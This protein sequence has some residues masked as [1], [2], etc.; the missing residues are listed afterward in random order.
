[1][2]AA[3][4]LF[5][6]HTPNNG[7][8]WQA[9]FA[10]E[11]PDFEVVAVP[12]EVDPARV[13]YLATWRPPEGLF[14]RF[15]NLRASLPMNLKAHHPGYKIWAGAQPDIDRV[16]EIW[17]ECLATYGGPFLF[18]KKRCMADAMFAPVV[19]RF[20]SYAVPMDA[21]CAAY[22]KT[23]A[24]MPEMKEWTAAAVKEAEEIEELD[25]EF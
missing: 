11:L 19:T 21:A 9:L 25:M 12:A 15:A 6:L 18:G 16:L 10:A 8:R 2:T 24:A 23:I 22:A 14:G 3:K 13:Q 1:M 5:Y 20:V 17:T 4:P 7:E